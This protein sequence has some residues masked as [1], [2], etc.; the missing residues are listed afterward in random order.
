[1]AVGKYFVWR[2]NIARV[3]DIRVLLYEWLTGFLSF[4]ETVISIRCIVQW[5]AMSFL[6]CRHEWWFIVP[7]FLDTIVFLN[8]FHVWAFV[9]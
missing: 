2:G 1:M 9:T 7:L 4:I 8:F 5:F 3:G 6:E